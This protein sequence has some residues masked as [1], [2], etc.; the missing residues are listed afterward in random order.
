M[1]VSLASTSEYTVKAAES[2]ADLNPNAADVLIASV[3]TAMVTE[4]GVCSPTSAGLLTYHD[5]NKNTQHTID[6]YFVSPA[7]FVNGS[8]EKQ[9]ISMTYG[10]YVET[11]AGANT[12]AIPGIY[13]I[14]DFL[15]NN[16]SSLP[17]KILL[18][19]PIKV[20]KDG[21]KLTQ[22]TKDYFEHSLVP[23][24]MWHEESS[25]LLKPIKEDLHNG[26]VILEK[27]S[28]TLEYLGNND[29]NCFYSGDIANEI[30][31][32]IK[33]EG[34]HA[35]S[36]DFDNYKLINDSKFEYSYKD[37]NITGHNGPSI[38]GLMVL[39]YLDIFNNNHEDI[40]KEL[41][42]TYI[43]RK[44]NLEFFGNRKDKISN[45]I[46]KI[47]SSPSTVQ[48][49]T[50]DTDNNHFSI[51][52]SSGYGSGVVCKNTGMYFNNSLGELEL[53]PQGFLGETKGERLISNMSPLIIKTTDGMSTIGSPGADRI[54]SSL[55]QVINNFTINHDW[56]KS[57]DKPRYHVNMDGSIRAEPGINNISD[58]ITVTE[59]N[60]MYFGGVCVTGIGAKLYTHGDKRRGDATWIN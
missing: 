3:I 58:N 60:D 46:K 26:K 34:G 36:S 56:K 35:T 2:I 12:F 10:G 19:Y 44:D 7:N 47:T 57:I 51:T 54:S 45:D 40:T 28:N 23:L 1:K 9:K 24:Y 27:L 11:Y 16:Y 18:E 15:H 48:V 42:D 43:Y 41:I 49:S 4:L 22:P 29:F 59:P 53:N 31:K 55:A 50:S 39:R 25:N 32:T 37:L 33:D 30:L 13:K 38:G 6:G 17:I 52:F 8:T 21:F 20:T 14:L 5:G